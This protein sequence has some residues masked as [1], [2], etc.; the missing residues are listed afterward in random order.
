MDLKETNILGDAIGEHWYYWSKAKAMTQLIADLE[1]SKVL[2]V[3]AG[4][5]FFSKHLLEH[6]SVT[7]AVCVDTNYETDAHQLVDHKSLLFRRSIGKSDANLVLFMDVLE[8]VDDDVGLLKIYTEKVRKGTY[9]LLTVPAFQSLWSS[10][11]VFLE[12]RRRYRL[13]EIENTARASDLEVLHGSYYFGFIFPIAMTIRKLEK[14]NPCNKGDVRSQLRLHHPFV[15]SALSKICEAEL[16]LFK[17]NRFA[18]LSAF[19][20]AKKI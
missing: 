12:H 8:H 3:G 7:E 19:V 18:G 1:I 20:L 10:H 9:F 17:Y 14:L 16:N 2:D 13:A 15:N 4:S 6:S 11:D 5:G